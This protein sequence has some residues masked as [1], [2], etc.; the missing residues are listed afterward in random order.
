MYRGGNYFI[1]L[2]KIKLSYVYVQNF[3][4]FVLCMSLEIN[5]VKGVIHKKIIKCNLIFSST[6]SLPLIRTYFPRV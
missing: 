4:G 6:G 3:I 1:Q 2:F 5:P